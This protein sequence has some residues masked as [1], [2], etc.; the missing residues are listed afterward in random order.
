MNKKIIIAIAVLLVAI[1]FAG[2]IVY[3]NG[4]VNDKNSQISNLTAHTNENLTFINFDGGFNGNIWNMTFT[5][6][7]TG[8]A[9]AIINN[10]IIDGQPYSSINPVPT[11]NPSIENGYALSPNQTVTITIEGTSTQPFHMGGELYV[12]TAIGNSFSHSLSLSS[13]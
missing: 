10:I 8:N 5:L 1:L 9:T 6:E 12:L 11:I 7:N 13:F 3:Y 2:T 4:V